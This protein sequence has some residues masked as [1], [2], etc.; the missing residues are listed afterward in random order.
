[1]L[2]SLPQ[3]PANSIQVHYWFG[4]ESHTMDA[5]VQNRCEYE[6]LG[7]LKEI[8]SSFN[9]EI[10][11]ETE[12]LTNG[13]L[14]RWFKIISKEENKK[15]TITTTII[16]VLATTLII[17]P[18]GKIPEKLI[19]KI[20]EDKELLEIEKD[21][22]KLQNEKL[23]LEIEELK[24]KSQRNT[25]LLNHNNVIR[26][27]K[28][29]FYE[30]L[31]KYPKVNE[32]SFNVASD[33]KVTLSEDKKVTRNNFKQYILVS[34]DLAPVEIDNAV[35]EIISPVLKK[36]NYKWMGIYNGESV[37]FNMKSKEFKTLV[38]TGEIKFVNGTSMNCFL[39]VR[40]KI[41]NEG[42][43]KIVG[44][45]VLRVNN[46][47]ENDKPIETPEGKHHRQKK[48]AE[49]NQLNLF[50]MNEEKLQ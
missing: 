40:K 41:D 9:A 11:I 44:Y 13:G 24:Q 32:V 46:Y 15:G 5:L 38:Q 49:R 42:L 29:N 30:A 16:V 19:D 17:T 1:M 7:I 37:P 25:E 45:D 50:G 22:K 4:D 18:L 6:F 33:D 23:R 36:G 39:V 27:K 48:E 21:G 3:K 2:L 14:R 34:D 20:F 43:E 8:A 28:S 31:E 47:F 10:I 26:K 35:L 12:P